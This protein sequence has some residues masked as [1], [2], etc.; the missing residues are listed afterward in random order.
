MTCYMKVREC[1][2]PHEHAKCFAAKGMEWPWLEVHQLDP[3]HAPHYKF[4]PP[5]AKHN[6][7][8]RPVNGHDLYEAEREHFGRQGR[9]KPWWQTKK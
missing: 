8:R 6:V 9:A 5:D 3:H 1:G 4:D 7:N 2:V